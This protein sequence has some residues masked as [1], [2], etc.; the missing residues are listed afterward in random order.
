MI[1]ALVFFLLFT[2][3]AR[4]YEYFELRDLKGALSQPEVIDASRAHTTNGMGHIFFANSPLIGDFLSKEK[5]KGK[6]VIE[7]GAG[8]SNVSQQALEKGTASY[9]VN[10]IDLNHLKVLASNINSA[11]GIKFLRAK[12]PYD[13]PK[14]NAQF[15][16]IIAEKVLH[17]FSD[18]EI[19]EFAK[20]SYKALKNGGKLY[21]TISTPYAGICNDEMRKQYFV[22]AQKNVDVPGYFKQIVKNSAAFTVPDSMTVFEH[23]A[24]SKLFEKYNFKMANHYYITL[25]P[26]S[27]VWREVDEKSSSLVAMVLIKGNG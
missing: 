24:L 7:I 25:Q 6:S 22:N 8:F 4:A 20:W 17:F 2:S 16:Y 1:R 10:D 11:R 23:A 3:N 5:L 14:A 19:Q 27:N 26:N 21:M 13:L 12:A 15:D 18:D 9:V